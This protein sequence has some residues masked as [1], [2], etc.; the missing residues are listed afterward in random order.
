MTAGSGGE[1]GRDVEPGPAAAAIRRIRQEAR[2]LR[3]PLI[4][5][6]GPSGA[7]K[8]TLAVA[9]ASDLGGAARPA[10]V[11]RLDDAYPGWD[12]L[13]R[14]AAAVGAGQ[15]APLRRGRVGWRRPW[16]W[17]AD[18]TLPPVPVRPAPGP[19]IVEGCGAFAAVG[20]DAGVLRVWLAAPD[21]ARRRRALERD[22]GR[23]D[24]FWDRW[25]VQWRRYAAGRPAARAHLVL[26]ATPDGA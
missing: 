4:A 9:V 18:R 12:G 22:E 13:D 14:G 24:P 26:R 25:E 23:F 11:I 20:D 17:D 2:R 10:R 15:L 8:S 1:R 16:D 5:I 6:D 7:G 19:L 21:V 3:A